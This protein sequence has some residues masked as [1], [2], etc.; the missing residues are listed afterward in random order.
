MLVFI[1]P[2]LNPHLS[3]YTLSTV[4][5]FISNARPIVVQ[6]EE[7]SA[8]IM[9]EALSREMDPWFMTLYAGD[10]VQPH[11]EKEIERWLQ[12]CTGRSPGFSVNPVTIIDQP[13]A[14]SYRPVPSFRFPRGPLLWRTKIVMKEQTPGFTTRDLLPFQKYVLI[15]KQLQ[16]STRYE[17]TEMVSDGI[18]YPHR[19]APA[20]MKE[21]EEWNAVSPILQ[22]AAQGHTPTLR[23]AT[24]PKVTIALCTYNDGEYL[25]WAV[26][27][28]LAQTCGAWELVILDDG[29]SDEETTAYLQRL[30]VDPRMKLV[31]LEENS[32]KSRALNQ[33]LNMATAPWLLELDADD[34]LPPHAL[35]ILLREA[36]S[37]QNAAVI[38]GDH[39]EW[40]ERSNKELVYQGVKAAPFPLSSLLLLNDAPAVAPRM[41]NVSI[42][43]QQKGWDHNTLYEGRLYEDIGLLFK[44]SKTSKLHHVPEALYHRR[45]RKAS[46]THRYPHRYPAYK[47]S[48][49]DKLNESELANHSEGQN[50]HI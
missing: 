46:M 15:D 10:A 1:L 30:P 17:W 6:I 13:T 9:N 47:S 19:I 33:I 5:R 49:I 37:V 4:K 20:W 3:E 35:E 42:I 21:A 32:G 2:G 38:Y 7:Q 40:L 8:A 44:L 16:L 39:M 18:L 27:S 43:K 34:W 48:L 14:T 26:R 36:E 41:F 31:R 25:P 12:T 28:V 11:A 24:P 50:A 29:S 22:A 23:A 45:L